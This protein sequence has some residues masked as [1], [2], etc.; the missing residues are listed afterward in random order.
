MPRRAPAGLI[1]KNRFI[2]H[3]SIQ[4]WSLRVGSVQEISMR[5]IGKFS[6]WLAAALFVVGLMI[7][8][9]TQASAQFNI[10]GMI[11]NGMQ[12]GFDPNYRYRGSSTQHAKSHK[13]NDSSSDKTKE[14]DATEEEVNGG[15]SSGAHQSPTGPAHDV[16][17]S[18]ETDAPS[19]G[20]GGGSGKTYDD[21]P[22][23][24]PSR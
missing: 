8:L 19:K 16:S 10:P 22:S 4:S 20:G 18:V 9:P 15:G 3:N 17:H 23:F 6:A 21:Q 14:K 12:H 5:G 1:A 11:L 7:L 24:A 2:G 13:D